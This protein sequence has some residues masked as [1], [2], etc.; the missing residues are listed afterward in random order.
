MNAYIPPGS[1]KFL[2][3]N[4]G[5]ATGV[6][7][8]IIWA[9]EEETITDDLAGQIRNRLYA[10]LTFERIAIPIF[11]PVGLFIMFIG[12]FVLVVLGILNYRLQKI[13]QGYQVIQ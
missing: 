11:V 10:V 2:Y 5:M 1:P 9:Y 3:Y 13:P 8:P 6:M 12:F 4:P 7:F